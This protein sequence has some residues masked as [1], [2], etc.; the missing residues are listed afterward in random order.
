VAFV[1]KLAAPVVFNAVRK[2]I[3]V[4]VFWMEETRMKQKV[5]MVDT[6]KKTGRP[7]RSKPCMA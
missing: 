6:F 4:F 3:L 7:S 1:N 2:D 5:K